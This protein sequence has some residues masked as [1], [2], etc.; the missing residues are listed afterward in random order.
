MVNIATPILKATIAEA[1]MAMMLKM[2][3]VMVRGRDVKM[4]AGTTGIT[5]PDAA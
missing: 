3:S 1:V 5:R 4:T 2:V